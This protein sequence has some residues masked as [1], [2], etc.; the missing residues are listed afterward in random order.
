MKLTKITLHGNLGEQVGKDWELQVESIP[1]AMH[2]INVMTNKKLFKTIIEND[3]QNVKYRVLVDGKSA[4][5]KSIEKFEDAPQSEI[6]IKRK[7]ETLDI[8]PVLEGA[9]GG[10]DEGKDWMMVFGGALTMGIGFGMEGAFGTT[11]IQLGLFAVVTGLSNLLAEPPEFEDFREI[12]AVNKRESY[13]FNGPINTYNP[14][15]P[16]PM[17]YG[18]LLV[19]SATVGFAQENRDKKIY[20]NGTWYP[21]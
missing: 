8:V 4:V 14:G 17:G 7:M 21:V 16:V 20:D 15:G 2:A 13:L 9:G 5:S 10:G 11:L 19:G 6:Y 12:D 3:K 1:E 18:R